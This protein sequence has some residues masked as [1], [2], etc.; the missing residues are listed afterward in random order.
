M[1][2]FWHGSSKTYGHDIGLSACFRQHRAKSHCRFL[3][4][5]ALAVHLEFEAEELDENNWVVD[6][7]ALKSFKQQ[8]EATF[9]HKLLI[10]HDDP[11]LRVFEDL[12]ARG[13]AQVVIVEHVG[14]EAFAELVFFMAEEWIEANGYTPRVRMKK[15]TVREHGANSASYGEA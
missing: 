6:F 10:A 8:L 14:C 12:E 15:V 4:G 7:G 1:S 5:Y 13:L 9:D 3:H 2:K 11:E